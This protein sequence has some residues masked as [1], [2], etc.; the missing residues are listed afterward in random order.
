[1]SPGPPALLFAAQE[2]QHVFGRDLT[3]VQNLAQQ[4]RSDRFTRVHGH[5][6]SSAIFV[7]QKVMTATN[8]GD[9]KS[10]TAQGANQFGARHA[11]Q[12]AHAAITTR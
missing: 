6:C 8:A 2:L 7:A 5:D 10:A 4:P 1:M 9:R 3:V 11:R 12:A